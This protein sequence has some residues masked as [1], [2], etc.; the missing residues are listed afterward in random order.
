M[1]GVGTAMIHFTTESP[2]DVA[3]RE[4]L[5]DRVM[6]PARIMKPSERLRAGRIPARGLAL[7][8]RDE[9]GLIG[10]VRL[11]NVAAAGNPMLLLGPLCVDPAAQ[12]LG[13]GAGLMRPR[14]LPR[15]DARPQGHRP[16]RRP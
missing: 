15:R 2:A 16:C 9:R 6:G 8:A 4:A 3:A 1:T 7:V 13:V 14:N 11:W 5:L 10:S 12:G